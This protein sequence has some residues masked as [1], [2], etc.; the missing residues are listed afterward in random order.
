MNIVEY[1]SLWYGGVSFEYMPMSGIAMSSDRTISNF[2]RSHQI[3]FKETKIPKLPSKV[4]SVK[5]NL[6]VEL[7][8]F[9]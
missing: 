6:E 1:L 8:P 3:D 7:F 2:L 4:Q 9:S 5:L